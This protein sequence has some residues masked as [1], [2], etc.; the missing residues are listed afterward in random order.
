MVEQPKIVG[1]VEQLRLQQAMLSHKLDTNQEDP[2][3]K[4]IKSYKA[5][6]TQRDI[7]QC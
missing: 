6:E 4:Q 3:I 1:H 2:M 7:G 5:L